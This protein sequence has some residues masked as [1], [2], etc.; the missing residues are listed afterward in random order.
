MKKI[1]EGLLNAFALAEKGPFAFEN[2]VE[3]I[4]KEV[5][6]GRREE[7]ATLG[8]LI[9][10]PILVITLLS[11]VVDNELR[12]MVGIFMGLPY[13]MFT[14]IFIIDGG[15]S[16]MQRWRGW[17]KTFKEFE[18]FFFVH[19]ETYGPSWVYYNPNDEGILGSIVNRVAEKLL[20]QAIIV[21]SLEGKD[22]F[23]SRFRHAIERDKLHEMH[24]IAKTLGLA[25]PKIEVYFPVKRQRNG[26]KNEE[27]D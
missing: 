13:F 22:D 10:F 26:G 15:T 8:F 14:M 1:N 2:S 25:N 24:R 17:K 11:V 7:K 23:N 16:S 18:R 6:K 21:V 9:A 20:D 12:V 27:N 3:E 19:N 5:L 4:K